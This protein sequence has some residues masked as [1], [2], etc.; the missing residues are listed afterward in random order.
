MWGIPAPVIKNLGKREIRQ[1]YY[2]S[3]SQY[4]SSIQTYK[5]PQSINLI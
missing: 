4:F 2:F 1:D 3:Q 5:K